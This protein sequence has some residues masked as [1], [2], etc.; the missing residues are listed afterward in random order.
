MLTGPF[1]FLIKTLRQ[2][3]LTGIKCG[4]L[5][6]PKTRTRESPVAR[7]NEILIPN[8]RRIPVNNLKKLL[9]AT[10]LM[11]MLVGT[12]LADC[13]QPNPGE[14]NG[15]P[16]T[17]GQQMTAEVAEQTTS[18]ATLSDEV[19]LVFLDLVVSGLENLLTVY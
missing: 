6:H 13:A 2:V 7:N 18:A 1:S 10:T 4:A 9:V 15:P 17:P 19:E 5:G 14:P 8:L 11:I 3:S 12:A 16:C